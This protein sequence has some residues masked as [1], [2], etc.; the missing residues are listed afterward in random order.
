MLNLPN[1]RLIGDPP[2]FRGM[3]VGPASIDRTIDIF[4]P[5]CGLIAAFS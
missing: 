4:G 2:K 3:G 1:H 5:A